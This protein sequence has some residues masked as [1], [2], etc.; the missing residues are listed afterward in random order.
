MLCQGV[1]TEPT[2]YAGPMVTSAP[3]ALSPAPQ[4]LVQVRRCCEATTNAARRAAADG[5][6][7]TCLF[8]L[9]AVPPVI[10]HLEFTERVLRDAQA[11]RDPP[12]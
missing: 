1:S 5:E 11:P 7:P 12:A 8:G 10:G 6:D 4:M 3:T 9:D 2:G